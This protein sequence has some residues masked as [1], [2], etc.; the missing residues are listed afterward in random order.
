MDYIKLQGIP[1]HYKGIPTKELKIGDVIC[2]N[3]GYKSEIINIAKSKTGKTYTVTVKSLYNESV[4][5]RKM[6]SESRWVIER[7]GKKW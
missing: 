4:H 6:G 3:Y 2:W 7:N 1:G 5:N